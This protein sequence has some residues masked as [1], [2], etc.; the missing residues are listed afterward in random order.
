MNFMAVAVVVAAAT[1]AADA[2]IQA[3]TGMSRAAEMTVTSEAKTPAATPGVPAETVNREA[4]S[5][6]LSRGLPPETCRS[7]QKDDEQALTR[8]QVETLENRVV[9]EDPSP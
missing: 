9:P 7:R 5:S 6:C 8:Q 2:G 3:R 4:V 1:T